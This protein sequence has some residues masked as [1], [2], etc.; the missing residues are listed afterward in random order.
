MDFAAAAWSVENLV[1]E[2]AAGLA[3]SKVEQM[4]Y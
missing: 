2:M 1:F 3:E 4:V